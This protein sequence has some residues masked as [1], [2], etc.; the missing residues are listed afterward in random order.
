MLLRIAGDS[1]TILG[2]SANREAGFTTGAVT[3]HVCCLLSLT[4]LGLRADAHSSL[5][6]GL[7]FSPS[8]ARL[9]SR[10]VSGLTSPPPT[11]L[12]ASRSKQRNLKSSTVL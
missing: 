7:A 3:K 12:L 11:K 8:T 4:T 5:E 2:H 10:L 9:S 6:E 1:V